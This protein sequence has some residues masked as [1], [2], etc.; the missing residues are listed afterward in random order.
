MKAKNPFT[1]RISEAEKIC[2]VT[3]EGRITLRSCVDLM[4][5]S[6]KNPQ[7]TPG[8]SV[9]V[10]LRKM[11]YDPETYEISSLTTY[12]TAKRDYFTGRIALVTEGHRNRFIADMFCFGAAMGGMRIKR[13][14]DMD[15]ARKWLD[16]SVAKK[17]IKDK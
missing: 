5:E 11:K 8:Y 7:T 3:A 17:I 12:V 1:Y 6:I 13:F 2:Y 16:E 10:D 14:S 9:L 15:E 4:E